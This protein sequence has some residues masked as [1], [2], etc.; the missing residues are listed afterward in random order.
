MSQMRILLLNGS[1]H[2]N[3]VTSDLVS[4]F[5]IGAMEAGRCVAC[6]FDVGTPHKSVSWRPSLFIAGMTAL[7]SVKTIDK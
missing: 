6:F 1:P 2:A 7:K 5:S 3:G 4:A